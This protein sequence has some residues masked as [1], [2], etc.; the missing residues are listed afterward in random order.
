[1]KTLAV[2]VG[3]AVAGLMLAGAQAIGQAPAERPFKIIALDPALNEIVAPDAK[4]ETLGD[5]FGLTA[6]RCAA[7]RYGDKSRQVFGW[8]Q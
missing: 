8:R 3:L 5:H 4:L 1:M 7:R 2:V 6:L